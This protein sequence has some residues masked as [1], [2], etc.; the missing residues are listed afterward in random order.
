MRHARSADP[1]AQPQPVVLPGSIDG[2]FF[3]GKDTT[4][5]IQTVVLLALVYGAALSV[6]AATQTAINNLVRERGL[7]GWM[8]HIGVI[9]MWLLLIFIAARRITTQSVL[10][11][12]QQ[13]IQQ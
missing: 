3:E 8:L 2:S 13:F 10:G 4:Q 6:H 12:V 5:I 1:Q 9:G 11:G 7:Q